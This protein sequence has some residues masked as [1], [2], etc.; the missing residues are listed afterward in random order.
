MDV[1]PTGEALVATHEVQTVM[2]CRSA[3]VFDGQSVHAD[4]FDPDL[5][6]PMAQPTQNGPKA[7]VKPA[8]QK[9]SV[10]FVAPGSV[11]EF[12]GQDWHKKFPLMSLNLPGA[13]FSHRL[14]VA[15]VYPTVHT[16]SWILLLLA[17]ATEFGGHD[18][19][20]G[21]PSG[22]YSVALQ[23]AHVSLLVAA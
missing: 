17:G 14:A 3:Y 23:L 2:P 11:Y 18:W 16:Q 10:K 7:P 20:T 5:Y 6:F 22:E 12:G 19:H 4:E 21:L 8:L 9:H 1:E 15:P 13:H